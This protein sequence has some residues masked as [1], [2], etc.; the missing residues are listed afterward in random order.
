MDESGNL[1]TLTAVF[2]WLLQEIFNP[3]EVIILKFKIWEKAEVES[4]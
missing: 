4:E 1:Y 2:I 3:N